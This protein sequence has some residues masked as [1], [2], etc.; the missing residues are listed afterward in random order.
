MLCRYRRRGCD[1][2]RSLRGE[3]VFP[4]REEDRYREKIRRKRKK[5]RAGCDSRSSDS[6]SSS[7]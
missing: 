1:G 6:C 4:K 5:N 3:K 2:R 7:R